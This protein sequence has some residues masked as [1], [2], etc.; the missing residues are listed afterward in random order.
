MGQFNNTYIIFKN[1]ENFNIFKKHFYSKKK[2]IDE[3]FGNI[4]FIKMES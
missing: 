3:I 1:V 2:K 4:S